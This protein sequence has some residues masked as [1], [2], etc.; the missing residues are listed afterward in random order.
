MEGQEHVFVGLI[1]PDTE[2]EIGV[3]EGSHDLAHGGS[4]IHILRTNLNGLL[5]EK[6]F[7]WQFRGNILQMNHQFLGLHKQTY[8]RTGKNKNRE[9]EKK[10]KPGRTRNRSQRFYSAK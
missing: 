1:I 5:S 2:N 7:N 4:L 10:E 6:N 8:V 3:R 9:E